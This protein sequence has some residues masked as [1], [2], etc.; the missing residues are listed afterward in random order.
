MSYAFFYKKLEANAAKLFPGLKELP[1]DQPVAWDHL[2]SPLEIKLPKAILEK[3][4]AAIRAFW[5]VSRRDTFRAQLEPVPGISDVEKKH[6]SV[7]MAY[8]FHTREDGECRLVEINT[9]AA[10]FL[11]TAL[12]DT[13]HG[14]RAD[15]EGEALIRLRESFETELKLWGKPHSAI[16]SV[17][18]TDEEVRQQKMFVEFLLYRDWFRSLGW[19]ADFCDDKNLSF[20]DGELFDCEGRTAVDLVYN[21]GTDFYFESPNSEGLLK[22]YAADSACITPNPKEYWLLADKQ[23]L[24]QFTEPE[25]FSRI[26]ATEAEKAA[27][28]QVII[29]TFEKSAFGSL[30]ELWTQRKNLFFKPKRSFGGKSV[31]RGESVSR[32]VFERLMAD[33]VLIQHFT[34]AQ[35]VP[36]DDPRSV[37][38]NWKFDLRFYVYGDKIQQVVARIYQ[39]QVTNFS[40]PLGGFT[41]VRF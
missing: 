15:L 9:N 6:A 28:Q 37:L 14:D 12:M 19:R 31:Y 20:E 40:S 34:P 22:A 32:K 29:P 21:R 11:L 5:S 7:L 17:A 3:A 41:K 24:I 8:D 33:D 27:I 23:R 4:E 35:R 25:F 38:T 16:P 39:G 36:T 2:I 13:V 30:D 18:I 1:E 10:G 26:G